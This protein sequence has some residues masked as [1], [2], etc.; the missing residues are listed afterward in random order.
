MV[1]DNLRAPLQE[2]VEKTTQ[3]NGYYVKLTSF[4]FSS[5]LFLSVLNSIIILPIMLTYLICIDL[6]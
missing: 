2:T 4:D 5:V 6:Y 3:L 1:T